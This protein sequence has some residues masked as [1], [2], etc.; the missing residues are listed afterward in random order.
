MVILVDDG[1]ATGAT[2]KAAIQSVKA[3]EASR[4]V[5]AVPVSPLDTFKEIEQLAEV[6]V[7]EIPP[8]F[9]AVGQF[10]RDF[11]A[12]ED[13]EVIQFLTSS[14]HLRPQKEN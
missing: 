6:V 2:M 10:Y 13:E 1:L 7:L 8:V 5:V 12:T 3:E 14:M 11:S 9:Y 4:V